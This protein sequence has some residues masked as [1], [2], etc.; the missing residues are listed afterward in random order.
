[1]LQNDMENVY[2]ALLKYE[3][4]VMKH[5]Q[6]ISSFVK[7][8]QKQQIWAQKRDW[9]SIYNNFNKNGYLSL[10]NYT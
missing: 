3:R 10:E 7:Q 2:N 1:M 5:I 8:Q 9:M 6:Y 4:Q